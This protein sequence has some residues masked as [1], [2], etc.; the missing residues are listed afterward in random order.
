MA[1]EAEKTAKLAAITAAELADELD[2][3]EVRLGKYSSI[4][5]W[6]PSISLNEGS[7]CVGRHGGQWAWHI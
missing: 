1:E 6:K 3:P 4:R 2:E 7:T 5:H